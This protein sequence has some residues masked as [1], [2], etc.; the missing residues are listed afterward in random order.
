LE[1]C[2]PSDKNSYADFFFAALN[3]AQRARV[4]AA[5]L[6][7]PAAEIFR[8]RFTGAETVAAAGFDPF[9]ASAHRFF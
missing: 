3:L 6:L 9:R 5:I 8:V 4:A 7:L 1:Q 2:W